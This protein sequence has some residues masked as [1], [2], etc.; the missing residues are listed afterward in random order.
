MQ[1]QAQLRSFPVRSLVVWMALVLALLVGGLGGY[2][3]RGL[4][5]VGSSESAVTTAAVTHEDEN[6][7]HFASEH[8]GLTPSTAAQAAQHSQQE[9]ADFGR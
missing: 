5:S 6:A 8:P 3:A 9:R 7:D 1:A 4:G 2:A